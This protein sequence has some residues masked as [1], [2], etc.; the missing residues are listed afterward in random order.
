[1]CVIRDSCD[2]H[3]YNKNVNM[4]VWTFVRASLINGCIYFGEIWCLFLSNFIK[5]GILHLQASE[6]A[7]KAS[8]WKILNCYC[9]CDWFVF[10]LEGFYLLF[11]VKVKTE[12]HMYYVYFCLSRS[13]RNGLPKTSRTDYIAPVIWFSFYSLSKGP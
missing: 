6:V 12:T 4:C 3:T 7:S 10:R 9:F 1:M 2:N 11:A 5:R 8:L 13:L